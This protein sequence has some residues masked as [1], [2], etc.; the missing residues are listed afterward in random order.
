MKKLILAFTGA[1]FILAG[2]TTVKFFPDGSQTGS[3]GIRYY[4]VKP[5]IKVEREVVNNSIVKVEVFYLPDLENPQCIVI[6]NGIGSAKV[7]L[8]LTEGAISTLGI[9]SDP[10]IAESVNALSSLISKTA[11]AVGDLSSFK[12][13]PSSQST[14]TEIYEVTMSNGITSL[15]KVDIK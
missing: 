9:S 5:F 1:F 4:T 10:Q 6:K 7:D 2:C 11:S 8:K 14:V 3:P 13:M 12:S 15:K